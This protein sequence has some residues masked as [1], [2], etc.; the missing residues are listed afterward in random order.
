MATEVFGWEAD[1]ATMEANIY[2]Q[3]TNSVREASI[4]C[5]ESPASSGRYYFDCATMVTG[6]L[7]IINDGTDNTHWGFYDPS[8]ITSVQDLLEG[9]RV[10]DKQTPWQLVITHKDTAAELLRK[11]MKTPNGAAITSIQNVLGALEELP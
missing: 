10:I 5:A 6:D 1:V 8:Q 3:R 9:D 11:T 2:V 4:A 7:I